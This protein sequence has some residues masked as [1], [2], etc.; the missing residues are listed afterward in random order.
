[1]LLIVLLPAMAVVRDRR[2]FDFEWHP[3]KQKYP[4]LARMR[5]KVTVT[6]STHTG[7][8][9]NKFYTHIH[10]LK[11]DR[12]IKGV[13]LRS[14]ASLE[15]STNTLCALVLSGT[16]ESSCAARLLEKTAGPGFFRSRGNGGIASGR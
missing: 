3:D 4:N 7:Y 2:Y 5:T 6:K 10:Y 9:E 13:V 8:E 15:L 12:H 11:V 14:C 16:W 1:M